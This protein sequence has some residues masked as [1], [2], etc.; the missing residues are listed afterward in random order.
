MSIAHV[1]RAALA[2]TLVSLGLAACG[3][4]GGSAPPATPA[5][6]ATADRCPHD[7]KPDRCPFCTPGLVESEGF[8]GA[9]GVP[10][11]YCCA[12]RPYMKAAFRA[13]GDWCADHDTP[14]S[15]CTAC[16]PDLEL[17]VTPGQHG[18]SG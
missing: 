15:Q 16:N 17:P 10:E 18:A 2:A 12:C 5:A 7:I 3:G 11:A 14:K 4:Q 9:H 1:S 8:C 6:A 13:K